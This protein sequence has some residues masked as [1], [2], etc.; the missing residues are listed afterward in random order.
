MIDKDTEKTIIKNSIKQGIT[1]ELSSKF[2][3]ILDDLPSNTGIFYLHK[4]NGEILYIGRGKN[5][6]I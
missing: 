3:V 2:Q 4:K 5:I 6:K 1:K